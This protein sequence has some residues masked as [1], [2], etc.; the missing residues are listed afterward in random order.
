M[1]RVDVNPV[2]SYFKAQGQTFERLPWAIDSA[3]NIRFGMTEYDRKTT[4]V[5]IVRLND[6]GTETTVWRNGG[7]L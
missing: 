4:D 3:S 6:D 7:R 2:G 1:F 5:E